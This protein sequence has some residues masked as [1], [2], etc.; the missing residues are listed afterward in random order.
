MIAFYSSVMLKNNQHFIGKVVFHLAIYICTECGKSK[1]RK[2]FEALKK[3]NNKG[4]RK[5][6]CRECYS[7]HIGSTEN[8]VTVRS[9]RSGKWR[10]EHPE[11]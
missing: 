7:H 10:R 3:K 9:N 6:L 1:P 5:G 8:L 11:S 4:I 2:N